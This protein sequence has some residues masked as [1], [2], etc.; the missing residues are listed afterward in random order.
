VIHV[1]LEH[2]EKSLLGVALAGEADTDVLLK[3]GDV[4]TIRQIG[5]WN[6][7]GR[8]HLCKRGSHASRP[9]WYR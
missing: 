9:L 3:A 2:R 4:L 6:D 5:G 1:D 8:R 7:I